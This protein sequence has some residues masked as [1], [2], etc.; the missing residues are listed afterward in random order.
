MQRTPYLFTAK[1]FD[2][3]TGLYYFGARYYDPRTSVWQNVDP[4]LGDYLDPGPGTP[5]IIRYNGNVNVT[6]P[7][8]AQV[9]MYGVP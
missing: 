5:F 7:H 8:D 1:E 3:E 2:E 6:N 9:P 4:I